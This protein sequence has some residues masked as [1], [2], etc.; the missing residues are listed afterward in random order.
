MLF[1][2]VSGGGGCLLELGCND[3]I[4]CVKVFVI[5]I[6]LVIMGCLILL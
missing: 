2:N 6:L 1:L 5:K 3:G 4:L